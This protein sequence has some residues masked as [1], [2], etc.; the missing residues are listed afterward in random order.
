MSRKQYRLPESD[1]LPSLPT[2]NLEKRREQIYPTLND[3]ELRQAGRF[4]EERHFRDGEQVFAA[5]QA[6]PDILF[7]LRGRL[8]LGR[9][10]GFGSSDLIA[11]LGPGQ[12]SGEEG[13]LVGR[14]AM[15]DAWAVGTLDALA[16]SPEALRMLLVAQADL[17]ERIVRAMILR[18]IVLV[19][20]NSGGP[21]I[22]APH[23]HPRVREL[24]RFLSANG[25]PYTV[26]DPAQ[27]PA[28]AGLAALH[29][30]TAADWPLVLCPGAA[31]KRDPSLVELGRCIGL[32]QDTDPAKIWDVV[33][34][35]A[36]P[37]G[38]ATAVYAAS[39]GLSVLALET[40]AYGGQ[41]AASARIENYFGFPTGITG[42]ALTGRA[43][44]Q[45]EKFGVEVAIP[46]AAAG[47]NPA[48]RPLEVVLCEG[49]G[50]VR[51]RTVVLACGARYRRPALANLKRFEG[52]GVYYWASPIEARLCKGS[53]VILVG[54]GNSA[55]QGA[56][57]LAG[58]ASKVHM[59]VRR[60]GLAETMS[61][62]L[63]SRIEATPNIEL[64]AHADIAALVGEEGDLQTVRVR[65]IRSRQERDFAVRH[66]F[67]FIGA[68]PNT[69]WLRD[70]G[71]EVDR[72][73]FI[74]TGRN[75]AAIGSAAVRK[76]LETS[77]P[78]VFAI[79]DVR[80]ESTK[81]V[82]AAVG[83]GAAVVAQIHEFL[84][85]AQAASPSSG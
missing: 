17:G 51:A 77:V 28:A 43:Y 35:G 1:D 31:P 53:E 20:K 19:R 49:L 73:G 40:R 42:G 26:H 11:I 9:H 7:I 58:H 52:R 47:L 63:V 8:A 15:E 41:A 78:G 71:I 80:A 25:H 54:G 82:A 23:G 59:L 46:A 4:G 22:V 45:A 37:A 67:L 21:V 18:R 5:G 79:G 70:S 32:F 69:G 34:V 44:V 60:G 10:D 29:G 36:G 64:H 14:P 56:V 38:L 85:E 39:E 65:D 48:S 27:D 6:K 24:E 75:V 16:L 62:Y 61:S 55:G 12:F 84:A 83:E 72:N 74:C 76:A 57:F 81:R 30:A 33:V 50:Q 13:Q 3:A 66:V 2:E 68:D